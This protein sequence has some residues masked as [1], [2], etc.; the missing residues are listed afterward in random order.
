KKK[1]QAISA[2]ANQVLQD[3]ELKAQLGADVCT[4]IADL[5]ENLDDLLLKQT[6]S[7]TFF[8]QIESTDQKEGGQSNVNV[9]DKQI[10]ADSDAS[11][12]AAGEHTPNNDSACNVAASS[13][14][15]HSRK[16]PF[17]QADIQDQDQP[18]GQPQS[19]RSKS[20]HFPSS[21]AFIT[22]LLLYLLI[23]CLC[24]FL[25]YK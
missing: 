16:R 10:T 2:F 4:E 8:V 23:F 15:C 18:L 11:I 14:A 7:I 20:Y 19:K 17:N 5:K 3:K 1:S 9:D 22:T 25:E 6:V 21:L 24:S 12:K 13:S